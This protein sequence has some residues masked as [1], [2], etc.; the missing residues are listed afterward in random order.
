VNDDDLN[1]AMRA[2]AD[3]L[4]AS[5]RDQRRAVERLTAELA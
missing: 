1:G 2:M 5:A 4:D 3:Q